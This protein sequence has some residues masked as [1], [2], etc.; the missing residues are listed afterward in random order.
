MY[1]NVSRALRVAGGI[2]ACGL[3]MANLQSDPGG[4]GEAPALMSQQGRFAPSLAAPPAVPPEART[5]PTTE[6]QLVIPTFEVPSAEAPVATPL[7]PA[8][9]TTPS[10]PATTTTSEPPQVTFEVPDGPADQPSSS[11]LSREQRV[12][13]E[14]L[15]QL[16]YPWQQSLPGWEIRFLPGRT[17]LLGATWP[18]EHQIDLYVRSE[19]GPDDVAHVLAHEMGHA[20]DVTWFGVGD[21]AEW[22]AARGFAPERAWFGQAG[23]SDYATPSG[24]FAEAFAVWQVGSAHYRGVAG[25]PAT[26]DQ[27]RLVA[28]LSA[29]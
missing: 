23:E 24:D 16:S 21:R 26:A 20:I 3:L 5:T 13:A 25:P 11:E 29:R 12:G 14:A 6:L 1:T 15:Q 4:A 19:H 17:G 10:P 18:E 28:Q 2:T 22:R 9:T 7:P 8:P 27:V